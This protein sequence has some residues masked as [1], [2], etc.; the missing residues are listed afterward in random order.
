MW[1]SALIGVL[2][3]LTLIASFLAVGCATFFGAEPCAIDRS[4]GEAAATVMSSARRD[5]YVRDGAP[6][7]YRGKRNPLEI[8]IAN[9][10]EGARLYDLRCAVCHGMM[11]VGDGE[12]GEKLDVK[13]ADLGR[14]LGETRYADDFFLWSIS[15]GGA[16][17][18]TDMPPFKTDLSERE[19]WRILTFMRAAFAESRQKPTAQDAV[20]PP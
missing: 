18:A 6:A 11:G 9:V 14:S 5:R 17:F 16:E 12:A 15:E 8:S 4:K 19:T 7:P 1:K 20:A 2:V 10:V 13:P 3:A